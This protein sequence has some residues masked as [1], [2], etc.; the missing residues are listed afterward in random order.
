MLA[1]ASDASRRRLRGVWGV[2]GGLLGASWERLGAT[3]GPSWG[4]LGT[5]AGLLG[6]SAAMY[7]RKREISK[8]IRKPKENEGFWAPG[9]SQDGAKTAS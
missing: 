9:G 4:H 3:L 7:G 5:F 2:S 8:N 1:F 6:P